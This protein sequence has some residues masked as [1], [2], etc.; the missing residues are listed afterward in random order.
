MRGGGRGERTYC[1]HT[2][3]YTH[4]THTAQ[5]TYPPTDTIAHRHAHPLI[6]SLSFSLS[7]PPL[8]L[9][10]SLSLSLTFSPLSLTLSFS[11]ALPFSL[12]LYDPLAMPLSFRPTYNWVAFKIAISRYFRIPTN[13]KCAATKRQLTTHT[14]ILRH[15]LKYPCV[16]SVHWR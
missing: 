5:H 2:H 16:L 3:T 14:D 9:S 8:S 1:D 4:N 12:P 7:P 15:V 10:L 11:L 13:W 6:L